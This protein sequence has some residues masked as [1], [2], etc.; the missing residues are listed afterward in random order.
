MRKLFLLI[1]SLI[2]LFA[3]L[4]NVK[5]ERL[6]KPPE[7]ICFD[8][9]HDSNTIVAPVMGSEFELVTYTNA[10][11]FTNYNKKSNCT[12]IEL[13]QHFL[14]RAGTEVMCSYNLATSKYKNRPL[15]WIQIIEVR[16]RSDG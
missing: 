13:N 6:E 14:K 7:V 3:F 9:G 4:L 12:P 5:S 11:C 1:T 8:V 2:C 16:I 10:Y 15:P